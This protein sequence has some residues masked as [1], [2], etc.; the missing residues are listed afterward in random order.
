M[1]PRHLYPKEAGASGYSVTQG[2]AVFESNLIKITVRPLRPWENATG[3]AFI[4]EL[5]EK[6]YVILKMAIENR[7]R[8]KTLYNPTHTSL[9]DNEME[10][11][12][13]MDYS[14]LYD[15][16]RGREKGKSREGELKGLKGLYYDLTATIPPGEAQSKLLIF[17]PLSEKG[18]RARLRI[19]E[20]YIG[21]DTISISF[22]FS[23][24]EVK[25][26]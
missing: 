5:L 7:S 2:A 13:P 21:T 22:P 14:D 19:K 8:E 12:K 3:S 17:P 24:R 1:G 26:P 25:E 11:R 15:A 10:Y 20:L 23:M 6:N 4:E 9:M 18:K 16:V